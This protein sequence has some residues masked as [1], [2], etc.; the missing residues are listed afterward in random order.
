MSPCLQCFRSV[1]FSPQP[2]A[3]CFIL[4][5][6]FHLKMCRKIGL[7]QG[8]MQRGKKWGN[9]PPQTQ[10]LPGRNQN[11]RQTFEKK[12]NAKTDQ[13]FC[14]LNLSELWSEFFKNFPSKKSRSTLGLKE[15]CRK[16]HFIILSLYIN[17]NNKKRFITTILAVILWNFRINKSR[18]ILKM[19]LQTRRKRIK[20]IIQR[21]RG[22]IEWF[23]CPR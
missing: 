11:W 18:L 13:K 3:F 9:P 23:H 20:V 7:K 10:F 17:E 21:K 12:K 19:K 2:Q 4:H 16:E 5:L 15:P 1:T 22:A 14:I 6:K 8:R